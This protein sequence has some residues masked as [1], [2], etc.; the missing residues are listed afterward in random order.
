[1]RPRNTETSLAPL[2]RQHL[3]APLRR[4]IDFFEHMTPASADTLDQHYAAD[5]YFK[6]PYNE[7]NDLASIRRIFLHMFEQV[8]NPRFVVHTAFEQGEQVFLGWHFLFEMK[9]FK[10]G[11]VQCCR[12]S[13]HVRLNK[14]GLVIY[15]RDYWDP[16]EELYEKIPVLGNLMRWI[17][18]QA[19]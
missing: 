11:Q 7:V 3:S 14:Q 17:K 1:M 5:A 19:G 4:L 6:D 12:G 15:H 16:A 8:N 13:T 9:Q 18:K 2:D 10:K